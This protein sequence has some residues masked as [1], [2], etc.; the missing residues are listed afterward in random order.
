[1]TFAPITI[2]AYNRQKLLKQTVDALKK[3]LL[4]DQSDLFIYADGSKNSNDLEAVKE[5]RVYL[6]SISGFKSVTV[7]EREKNYGLSVSIIDGVTNIVNKYG[8]I[9]VL[10][11]DLV[12]SPYFLKFIN[13]ALNMYENDEQVISVQ[14]YVYPSKVELPDCFFVKGADCQG[15]ATWKR[16]WSLFE[17]DSKLLLEELKQ[18]K[19][20]K[21]FNFNNNYPYFKMLEDQAK[22]LKNSWAIRWYASA[23][24]NDKF[25]LYPGKSLIYNTGFSNN[26]TNTNNEYLSNNFNS[27]ISL[28]PIEITKIPVINS[29]IGREA[30]ICFFKNLSL[31]KNP[32]ALIKHICNRL[33]K[34]Q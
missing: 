1:M 13:D 23:Y 28:E 34:I 19:L 31:W 6:K 16:G 18:K 5:V 30:F 32:K 11:D 29:I 12:T 26:G 8:K 20:I 9:I 7:F 27:I 15:W 25:T 17:A 33:F 21:D 4:A 3:N 24:L 14:G 2:F 10:E 22:G